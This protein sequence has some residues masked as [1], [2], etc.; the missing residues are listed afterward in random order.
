MSGT[1]TEGLNGLL[2]VLAAFCM[3]LGTGMPASNA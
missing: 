3:Q 1:D 2:C